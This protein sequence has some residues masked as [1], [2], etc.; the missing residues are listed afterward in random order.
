MIPN[1]LRNVFRIIHTISLNLLLLNK[2]IKLIFNKAIM[3]KS[4]NWDTNQLKP[5]Q[6]S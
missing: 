6:Y 5:I 1:S 4:R 3:I 2:Q